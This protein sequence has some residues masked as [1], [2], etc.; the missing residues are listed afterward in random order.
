[1]YYFA[2]DNTNSCTGLILLLPVPKCRVSLSAKKCVERRKKVLSNHQM[3]QFY[4]SLLL[5]SVLVYEKKYPT[6]HIPK[7]PPI[8]KASFVSV[9]LSSSAKNFELVKKTHQNFNK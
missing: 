5:A 6:Q 3:I 9:I 1:M 4:S 7:T 2:N 8:N